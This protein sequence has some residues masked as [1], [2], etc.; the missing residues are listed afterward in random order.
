MPTKGTEV[1]DIMLSEK[2]LTKKVNTISS[3]LY[4]ILNQ[5]ILI[6]GGKKSEE[7]LSL[8]REGRT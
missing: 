8:G 3:Y 7:Q 1:K 4:E 2:S 5:S 6:Y